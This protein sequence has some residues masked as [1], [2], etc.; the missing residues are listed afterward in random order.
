MKKKIESRIIFKLTVKIR[1]KKQSKR[2][3]DSEENRKE[4]LL[5]HAIYYTHHQYKRIK[6][7][8]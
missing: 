2:I 5:R 7:N 1:D 8:D 3:K 6:K 4:L